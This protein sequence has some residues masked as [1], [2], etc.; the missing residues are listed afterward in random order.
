MLK[1]RRRKAADP[2]AAGPD[3]LRIRNLLEDPR[4]RSLVGDVD[5]ANPVRPA[6]LD[7]S[8]PA[9]TRRPAARRRPLLRAA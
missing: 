6:A 7:W 1:F 3:S 2:A 4:L 8:R 9:R 5:P